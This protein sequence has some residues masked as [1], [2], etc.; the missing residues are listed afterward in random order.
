MADF[1]TL[2]FEQAGGIVT[3]TVNR[4]Q[5]LNALNEQVQRELWLAAQRLG[6]DGDLACAEVVIL[7]GAGGKAFVAGADIKAMIDMTPVQ[8]RDFS[9][10]GHRAFDAIEALPQPVIAAVDG[11]ALGGGLE[12]AMACDF[13]YASQASRFGAPEVNL[14]VV[15]GY[16]GTQRLARI[17]GVAK[18][19]ELI[20]TGEMIDAAEALRIGLV[21]Q[22]YPVEGFMDKVRERAAL[23]AKRGMLAVKTA[24]KVIN[25][26][27]DVPVERGCEMERQAFGLLFGTEDRKEGMTAFLER[28]E[29]QFKGR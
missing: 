13:I 26:G 18:A 6:P 19:R 2:T 21:A 29:P 10:L 27:L 3:V 20:Y 22:V 9:A 15:P 23:I 24:K 25:A 16:G 28:R 11:F 14:G 5:K 12:L 7:T 8:G 17:V 1:E 4:P